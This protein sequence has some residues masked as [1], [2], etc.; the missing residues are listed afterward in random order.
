MVPLGA[1]K[2]TTQKFQLFKIITIGWLSIFGLGFIMRFLNISIC[3]HHL[4]S[5]FQFENLT[6]LICKVR[7]PTGSFCLKNLQYSIYFI[8]II[9][10]IIMLSKIKTTKKQI[11][12]CFVVLLIVVLLNI[13]LTLMKLPQHVEPI[14][15]IFKA[16][17]Q[18]LLFTPLVTLFVLSQR[19]KSVSVFEHTKRRL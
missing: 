15:R 19:S 16:F 3:D 6:V 5:L 18:I 14:V 8:I 9:I 17:K 1:I 13:L 11:F 2:L 7:L 12:A 10:H 4:L